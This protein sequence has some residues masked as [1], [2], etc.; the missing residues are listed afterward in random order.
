MNFPWETGSQKK[1]GRGGKKT[2]LE[3]ERERVLLTAATDRQQ[4][5]QD[6]G[7]PDQTP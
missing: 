7:R 6:S 4:L 2:E 5:T 1:R 3:G